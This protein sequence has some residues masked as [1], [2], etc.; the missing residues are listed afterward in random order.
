MVSEIDVDYGVSEW[1]V[2]N[3]LKQSFL[4]KY[5]F[6][7]ESKICLKKIFLKFEL[8]HDLVEGSLHVTKYAGASKDIIEKQKKMCSKCL[9]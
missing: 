9:I 8:K 1:S 6:S 4:H 3:C 2:L 5:I 7:L